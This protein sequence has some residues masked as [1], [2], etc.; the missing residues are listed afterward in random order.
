MSS[1]LSEQALWNCYIYSF[2]NFVLRHDLS[3]KSWCYRRNDTSFVSLRNESDCMYSPSNA[4][5]NETN[6]EFLKLIDFI[7]IELYKI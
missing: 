1:D 3:F 5:F 4:Y 2:E 6:E 7:I